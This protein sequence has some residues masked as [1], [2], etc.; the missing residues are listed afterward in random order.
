MN[1]FLNII[2]YDVDNKIELNL[3]FL[4]SYWKI[5]HFTLEQRQRESINDQLKYLG[6]TTD[7]SVCVCVCVCVSV[8]VYMLKSYHNKRC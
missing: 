8:C 4:V 6:M 5:F 3:A 1:P 2:V 7:I